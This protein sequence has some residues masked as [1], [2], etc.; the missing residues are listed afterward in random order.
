MKSLITNDAINKSAAG[1]PGCPSLDS[2]TK[3]QS[4]AHFN[5]SKQKFVDANEP[6]CGYRF[7]VI[8][9]LHDRK[10]LWVRLS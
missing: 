7:V 6:R 5:R 8:K 3:P 4:E 2:S 9:N 1:N 10:Y